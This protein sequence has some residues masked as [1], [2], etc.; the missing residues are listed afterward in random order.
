MRAVTRGE[1]HQ[2]TNLLCRGRMTSPSLAN[3]GGIHE[4]H[5]L[6][7]GVGTAK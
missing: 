5:D 2:T 3:E 1:Q 7:G 4:M 6:R